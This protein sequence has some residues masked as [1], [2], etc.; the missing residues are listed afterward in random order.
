MEY[1]IDTLLRGDEKLLWHC[2]H[3]RIIRVSFRIMSLS[4]H[5]IIHDKNTIHHSVVSMR[6]I[7]NDIRQH[8]DVIQSSLNVWCTNDVNTLALWRHNSNTSVEM[9]FST[10]GTWRI[11]IIYE[12]EPSIN[13]CVSKIL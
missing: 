4:L 11:N 8:I 6:L 3:T 1:I 7:N 13:D 2:P 5:G 12:H 9:L 10:P